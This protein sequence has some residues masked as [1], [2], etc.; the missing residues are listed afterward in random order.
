MFID[1]PGL[2]GFSQKNDPAKWE[3]SPYPPYLY[4]I[5][6]CIMCMFTVMIIVMPDV[7]SR[8]MFNKSLTTSD[9][10]DLAIS[11]MKYDLAIWQHSSI[12]DV[13]VYSDS[14]SCLQA[15][16]GEDTENPCICHIMN[17]LWLLSDKGTHVRLC[18]I[19]SHCD[20]EGNERVDKLA[21]ET[22]DPDIDPLASV[23][24][25]D[26][27]PLVKSDIQKLVQTKW[28]VAVHGRDFYLVKPTLGPPKK[29]QRLTRTEE[30]VI[31]RLRFG[32]TK[33]TK[34]HI[35][36]RGPPTVCHLC[37]YTLTI[38]HMLLECAVIQE[39]RD[40]YYTVNSLN[41]PFETIPET[42]IVEFLR[43]AGFFYLIWCN[44]LTSTGPKTW[45]IW[46]DLSNKFREWKQLW[47]TFTWVGRL[48]CPE[49]RVSSLNKSNPIQSHSLLSSD[50]DKSFADQCME[51][52]AHL[53]WF[54][55]MHIIACERLNEYICFLVNISVKFVPKSPINNIPVLA[56]IMAWRRPGNKPLSEGRFTDGYMRHTASIVKLCPYRNIIHRTREHQQHPSRIIHEGANG[57][58]WSTFCN[59]GRN[60]GLTL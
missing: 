41:T 19:P 28:D 59:N 20:N 50:V 55:V 49:G 18:W 45:T 9:Q 35:L 48:I 30:V 42:C 17:L 39:C 36:S 24:Y 16:E 15:I 25:T 8:T 14:M 43:D 54:W 2:K 10:W 26:I 52:K 47:G 12:H 11:L 23:H 21:K 60:Y 56:Q 46:S 57:H 1:I 53:T 4:V 38:D 44:L 27:K 29:F 33:A 3:M 31:T 34:S 37:G 5:S 6:A 51:A 7:V 13:V 32:H 40:E 22:L 58:K